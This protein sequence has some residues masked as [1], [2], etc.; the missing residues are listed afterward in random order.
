LPPPPAL[1]ERRRALLDERHD[2]FVM[3]GR[4]AGDGG[5]GVDPVIAPGAHDGE[6]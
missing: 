5:F 6:S 3:L 1:G 4:L 2:G